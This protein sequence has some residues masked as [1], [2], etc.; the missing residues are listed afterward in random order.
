MKI[1]A[2]CNPSFVIHI[3]CMNALKPVEE[4]NQL[5]LDNTHD[6]SNMSEPIAGCGCWV[7]GRRGHWGHQSGRGQTP[8]HDHTM[9]KASQSLDEMLFDTDYDMGCDD[10]SPLPSMAH[11]DA[12]L[13]YRFTYEDTC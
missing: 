7:G 13:S 6:A 8:D 10:I 12:G 2:K 5:N 3:E 4:L 1:L 9:E 11:D